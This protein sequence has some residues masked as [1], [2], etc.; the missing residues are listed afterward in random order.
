MVSKTFQR[1]TWEA[2][3]YPNTFKH[4]RNTDSCKPSLEAKINKENFYE[5]HA[6]LCYLFLPFEAELPLKMA[7][8]HI[9][10]KPSFYS[11]TYVHSK[12]FV[13]GFRSW[14]HI[15]QMTHTNSKAVL[16][17]SQMGCLHNLEGERAPLVWQKFKSRLCIKQCVKGLCVDVL[18]PKGHT[19]D[20]VHWGSEH[21]PHLSGRSDGKRPNRWHCF[22]APRSAVRKKKVP[23]SACQ[24]CLI[25]TCRTVLSKIR[26]SLPECWLC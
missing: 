5:K 21:S 25:L 14:S 10:Y 13:N 6:N 24:K 17:C 1:D 18:L 11:Y 2:V 15:L 19:A 20:L 22:H 4:V 16:F 12:V 23:E 7:H 9:F 3:F 26:S 8:L